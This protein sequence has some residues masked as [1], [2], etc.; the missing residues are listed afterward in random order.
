MKKF[1]VIAIFSIFGLVVYGQ[2]IVNDRGYLFT[3][4]WNNGFVS[5]DGV[6]FLKRYSSSNYKTLVKY[7][8]NKNLS[9]YTIPSD[10]LNIARGAFQ[11]NKYIRTLKIPSTIQYIGDNAFDGC[12]QL[13]SIEVYES[14]SSVRA[15]ETDN[16]PSEAREVGRYNIQGVKVQEDENG[17]VQII[18][19]SDGTSQKVINK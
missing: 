15:V 14:T 17:Q 5:E 4:A 13:T 16:P 1:V 7:P 12:D 11:G 10:V 2:D 6:L 3:E 9:S 19:Y 8:Q 18:L